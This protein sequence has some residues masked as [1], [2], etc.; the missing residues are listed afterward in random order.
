MA[1]ATQVSVGE[2]SAVLSGWES[3]IRETLMKPHGAAVQ[4]ATDA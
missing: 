3:Q 1:R 4:L 2:V